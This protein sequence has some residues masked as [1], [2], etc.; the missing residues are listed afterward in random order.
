MGHLSA[1]YEDQL[2]ERVSY[3]G[4][5]VGQIFNHALKRDCYDRLEFFF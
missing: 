5:M 2:R 4:N 3:S 1:D